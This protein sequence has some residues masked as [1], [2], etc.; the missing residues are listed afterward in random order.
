MILNPKLNNKGVS[1]PLVIGLVTL[2]M[3]SSIAVSQL[4]ILSLKSASR[5][6]ASNRAYM[7]AEG[8]IE[9]A[10]YELTP[11]FAG[12]TTP[13][14]D[15][16]EVRNSDFGGDVTWINNWEIESHNKNADLTK[17]GGQFYANQKLMIYLFN[18]TS[19]SN[20]TTPNVINHNIFYSKDILTENVSADFSITFSIPDPSDVFINETVLQIDN[21]G[22]FEL[23]N[24]V[25]EDPEGVLDHEACFENPEDNDC[26]GKVDEDNEDDPVILWKLTDGASRSLIPIKG[27]LS[28]SGAGDEKSEICEKDF[29]ITTF[30]QY[31]VTLNSSSTGINQDGDLETISDFINRTVI[32]Y[33]EA[34]PPNPVAANPNAKLHFEFLIIAPLEH[35]DTIDS[36]KIEIPYI[37]Y[38]VSSSSDQLPYPFFRIKSDGYYGTYKQSIT[39]TVTPK[40][41]VPLF[42]FTIIQQQ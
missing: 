41:T 36:K 12:Y 5:I 7:A 42:D 23:N 37:E 3:I 29:K 15:D 34:A 20:T 39:T 18:D 24:D 16:T 9:D 4:I 35:V 1:M 6:E 19:L 8:G 13:T 10:L 32:G 28:D 38:V 17:W 21:D 31:S 11:H 2:L 33:A 14:L 25:N 30:P 22:D 40:T 27:C 26:D